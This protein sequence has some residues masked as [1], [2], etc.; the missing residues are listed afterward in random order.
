MSG[1]VTTYQTHML[2]E[3]GPL[4]FTLHKLANVRRTGD[5]IKCDHAQDAPR[6]GHDSIIVAKKFDRLMADL[7]RKMRAALSRLKE[8]TGLD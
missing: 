7:E 6:K 4:G 8:M 1:M 2:P 5:L 3:T